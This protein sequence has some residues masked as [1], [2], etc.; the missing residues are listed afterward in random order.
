MREI[1]IHGDNIIE[2][3]RAL[4]LLCNA[5]G[6]NKTIEL[7]NYLYSPRYLVEYKDSIS[8]CKDYL[9]VR[10]QPKYGPRRWGTDILSKLRKMGGQLREAPDAIITE[11]DTSTA[12][13]TILFS[14]EFCSALPAGNQAW[15]RSGRAYSL[16]Q[17][18]VPYFY[19]VDVGGAELSNGRKNRS[20]R[21]PNPM[22]PVSY[23]V[24]SRP[25]IPCIS[26]YAKS[27]SYDSSSL[28]T[29]IVFGIEDLLEWI[30][31]S[32]FREGTTMRRAEKRLFEKNIVMAKT[33]SSLRK[34]RDCLKPDEIEQFALARSTSDRIDVLRSSGLRWDKKITI[35]ELTPTL[36]SLLDSVTSSKFTLT[37]GT[38]SFP[39]CV[40]D[41]ADRP[42]LSKV[43]AAVYSNNLQRQFVNGIADSEKPLAIVWMAGYKPRGEDSRPDRGLVPLARMLL[44]D[45]PSLDIL[46]VVYGPV[47]E[48][49]ST[50]LRRNPD[51]LMSVNGLWEAVISSSNY[52]L[53]DSVNL[54]EPIALIV[55]Y[56]RVGNLVVSDSTLINT[57]SFKEDDVD[58]ALH[59]AFSNKSNLNVFESFCNPPGGDWSGISLIDWIGHVIYRWTS[60]P[61]VSGNS[62]RPDH[63][64]QFLDGEREFILSIESK[65]RSSDLDSENPAGLKDYVN[66]LTSG[67]PNIFLNGK[68]WEPCNISFPSSLPIVVFSGGAFVSKNQRELDACLRKGFDIAFG[69]VF[70]TSGIQKVL[71]KA[72]NDFPD[73]LISEIVHCFESVSSNIK[74]EV[75]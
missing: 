60:L 27:P 31:G 69:F 52:V 13:E 6:G 11:I 58:T 47:T 28:P 42:A 67:A 35:K 8:A 26:V 55:N 57:E 74:I 2:C 5:I 71:I 51:L 50:L 3:D 39:I 53:V 38:E 20:Q 9:S 61:R 10:L 36:E 65:A 18:A 17:S 1:V 56:K 64:V 72:V 62:K 54:G 49:H 68:E 32:F 48:S 37:A 21:W 14:I 41:R 16:S 70:R 30:K 44:G 12:K 25:G 22:V 7:Q 34:T 15:Q 63:V 19:L 75:Y 43:F 73:S 24:A 45:P 66:N 59:F 4:E 46:V 33:L 29:D 40:V 23:A